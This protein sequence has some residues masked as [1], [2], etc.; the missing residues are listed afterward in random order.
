MQN[1]SNLSFPLICH[2]HVLTCHVED[3]LNQCHHMIQKNQLQ[4]NIQEHT[5]SDLGDY[6]WKSDVA[7]LSVNSHF[8]P[9]ITL[10]SSMMLCQDHNKHK[11]QLSLV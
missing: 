3:D 4:I 11:R 5:N 8:Y 1:L 2:L 6:T 7:H 10:N 9:H